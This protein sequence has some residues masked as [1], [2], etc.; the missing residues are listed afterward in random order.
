MSATKLHC[1]IGAFAVVFLSCATARADDSWEG[2]NVMPK[3]S[4]IWLT[5]KDRQG[6]VIRVGKLLSA[7][8]EVMKEK[9]GLLR[10]RSKG[11]EGWFAKEDAVL[12]D[13]AAAYFT[14]R[15]R[16]EPKNAW[17]YDMRGIARQRLGDLDN[18]IEDFSESIRLDPKEAS[19][20]SRRASVWF[21]K[22]DYDNA[23]KDYD[24]AI[25]LDPKKLTYFGNRGRSWFEKKQYERAIRDYGEVIRL[26]PKLAKAFVDRGDAW[27]ELKELDKA[28]QDYDAA[29][30]LDPKDAECLVQRA[31]VWYKKKHYDKARRDCDAAIRLNAKSVDML[32]YTARVLAS[33]PQAEF[34]DGKRAV[35]LATDACRLTHWKDALTLDA[36]AAA[37][38]EAG[39]FG[40]AV[41]WQT[42]ALDDKDYV[43]NYGEGGRYKLTLYMDGKPYRDA[44]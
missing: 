29:I 17:P 39:D 20:Y 22:K 26:N 23:I 37:Y 21:D 27:L 35:E 3:K 41:K 32:Q 30:G 10:V 43:D 12:L 4:T 34:R 5:E 44:D 1:C 13:D 16:V 11:I 9:D 25:R 8:V 2:K 6:K 33:C 7:V 31:R 24:E 40:Q 36:L 14:E 38:A 15:I 19:A 42:K 18:A 28:L